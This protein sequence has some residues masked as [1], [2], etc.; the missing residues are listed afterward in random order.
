MQKI[1]EKIFTAA[2]NHASFIYELRGRLIISFDTEA[3]NWKKK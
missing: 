1:R 3:P 2:L